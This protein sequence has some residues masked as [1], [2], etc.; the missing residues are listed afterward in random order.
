MLSSLY[1]VEFEDEDELLTVEWLSSDI[2][3][4]TSSAVNV[5]LPQFVSILFHLSI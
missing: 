1:V 2:I 5:F 3:F 4:N